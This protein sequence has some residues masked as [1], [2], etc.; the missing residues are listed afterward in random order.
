MFGK[1]RGSAESAEDKL[2]ELEAKFAAV[3]RSQALIE[4]K[5]DGTILW[6]NDNFLGA[7]GYK[8]SEIVG[9]HHRIFMDRAERES[10]E[11]EDFWRQL[12][13][14][15]FSSQIFR[16]ITKSEAEIYIQA[17][18]N[19]IINAAGQTV[20]VMKIAVDVTAQEKTRRAMEA[21]RKTKQ[22]EQELVVSALADSLRRLSQGDLTARITARFPESH[23]RLRADFN[24]AIESLDDALSNAVN[25][26]ESM[27]SGTSEIA[28][29][30]D[31][32]SKRT[33]QQAATLEQTA[34]AL[35][36]ITSTVTRGAAGAKQAAA[37][38][39]DARDVAARSGAVMNEA[40]GAMSEIEGSAKKISQIIGVIDEIAFQTNL[41]A[42]N[43]GVEAARAGEAGRGFAV[44]AQ[45][46][47]AL[48]QRSADAAKE[49]K[50]LISESSD[51]VGRGAKL[52]SDTGAAL[53]GI[54]SK[55]AEIDALISDIAASAQEQATGLNQI[56][57]AVNNMD[58][59]TQKNAAM[60]EETTAAAA[61]LEHDAV[62]LSRLM[63]RFHTKD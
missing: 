31:D 12:R 37:T 40:V 57:A 60:V 29:A 27:K 14:G 45:E 17:S 21:E 26:A 46:V 3:G 20:K 36:T 50:S 2:A 11:Y 5:P 33:E 13:S 39:A 22:E 7:M 44:V 53:S 52:V 42:L 15:Q 54:V 35:D 47:R 9:Q 18:Y 8:L 25:A 49:I 58:Q 23:E 38:A 19:P 6:A 32:L 16:R 24:A 55:V 34:A 1:A 63:T 51:Q 62:N 4:F 59:V 43:A 30:A 61:S 48:A 28:S 56:N 41:L 10:P